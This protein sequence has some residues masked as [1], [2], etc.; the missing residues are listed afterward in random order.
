MKFCF[1]S[2][3]GFMFLN[4]LLI[5]LIFQNNFI[6]SFIYYIPNFDSLIAFKK[7]SDKRNKA[8]H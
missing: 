3:I 5:L 8:N 2:T 4:C 7:Y 1:K 6:S